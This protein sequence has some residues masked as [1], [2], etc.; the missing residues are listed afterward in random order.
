MRQRLFDKQNPFHHRLNG[1]RK[2]WTRLNYIDFTIDRMSYLNKSS[3]SVK[4]WAHTKDSSG[5]TKWNTRMAQERIKVW[6]KRK[7]KLLCITF[8]S[9]IASCYRR[10]FMER[11]G[12][13]QWVIKKTIISERIFV[14]T[15]IPSWCL[16]CFHKQ[17]AAFIKTHCGIKFYIPIYY[18][19]NVNAQRNR[20][21]SGCNLI[22]R[23]F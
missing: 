10:K 2:Q 19:W 17:F 13:R 3:I 5:K 12:C 20:I 21:G 6:V 9:E 16:R 11:Q 23:R 22:I 14:Q 4:K 18:L 7:H 1:N 8:T 15:E